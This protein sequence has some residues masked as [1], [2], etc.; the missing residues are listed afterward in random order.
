[1]HKWRRIEPWIPS[2][3]FNVTNATF[4]TSEFIELPANCAFVLL[5]DLHMCYSLR[6]SCLQYSEVRHPSPE[7]IACIY[8]KLLITNTWAPCLL[9]WTQYRNTGLNLG[10]SKNWEQFLSASSARFI[11]ELAPSAWNT[12]WNLIIHHLSICPYSSQVV[13]MEGKVS[14]MCPIASSLNEYLGTVD[15]IQENEKDLLLNSTTRSN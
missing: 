10:I 1:M 5:T 14:L 11:V 7:K 9:N 8:W 12:E 4:R 6:V 3:L 13:F 2:A 15:G